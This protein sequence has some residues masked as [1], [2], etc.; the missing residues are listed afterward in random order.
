[1]GAYAVQSSQGQDWMRIAQHNWLVQPSYVGLIRDVT[2][3][4][5]LCFAILWERRQARLV[6]LSP[7][8]SSP[9]H[10]HHKRRSH[11]GSNL[12]MATIRSPCI[13]LS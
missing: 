7:A 9:T 3:P 6:F 1:M 5:R 10:P 12:S 2:H 11:S 13:V 4:Y 8:L